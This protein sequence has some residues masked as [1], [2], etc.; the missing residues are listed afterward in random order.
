MKIS[1]QL[2]KYFEVKNELL[3]SISYRIFVLIGGLITMLL[4]LLNFSPELQGYYYTFLSLAALQ[5]FVEMG[6]T[7]VLITFI[8]HEW[9]HLRLRNK[10][11][12]V[13]DRIALEKIR[14][15]AS[16]AAKWFSFGSGIFF[17]AT[18]II[19]IIFFW[20]KNPTNTSLWLLPWS[21]FIFALSVNILLMPLWAILEGCNQLKQVYKLR[22]IISIVANIATWIS[23]LLGAELLACSVNILIVVSLTI[24]LINKEY[25]LFFSQIFFKRK[26]NTKFN[27]F[28]EVIPLQWRITVSWIF[29]YLSF[30]L[31][32][33]VLFYYQGADIA[34]QMGVTWSLVSALSSISASWMAIMAPKFAVLI[35]KECY[36]E[37]DKAFYRS[38]IGVTL[39]STILGTLIYLS[40]VLIN[41]INMPISQKLLSTNISALFIAATIMQIITLPFSTYLRAH[42][43]EPMLAISVVS[44]ISIASIVFYGSAYYS[45]N[46]VAIG[47]FLVNALLCPVSIVTW[48]V[49]RR[50]WH[51]R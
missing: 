41:C 25:R 17:I 51:G 2:L 20:N 3:L 33:P 32:V 18:L 14:G 36:K 19:G 35:A 27:W 8:G 39:I 30:S 37:L 34:G 44:G 21:V 28:K 15:L 7:S 24:I 38:L 9:A 13:G 4:V 1:G 6:L 22:L 31:F 50:D 26:I 29:G 12:I 5:V 47:Y 23:I 42:K 49:K 45:I 48:H 10:R 11:S 43:K 46:E 40:I 16:Y